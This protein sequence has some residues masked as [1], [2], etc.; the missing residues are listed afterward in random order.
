MQQCNTNCFQVKLI[1]NIVAK[2]TKSKNLYFRCLFKYTESIPTIYLKDGWGNAILSY[3]REC[4]MIRP[5]HRIALSNWNHEK[6]FINVNLANKFIQKAKI[7]HSFMVN[8]IFFYRP[9]SL[10]KS[11]HIDDLKLCG[12]SQLTILISLMFCKKTINKRD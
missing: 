11:W 7:S 1:L 2:M 9:D 12:A 6:N 10:S 3:L 5:F 4:G 8:S